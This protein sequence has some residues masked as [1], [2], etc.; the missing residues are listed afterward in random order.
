MQNV[1][2]FVASSAVLKAP[3]NR[4]PAT[5]PPTVRKPRLKYALGRRTTV[6]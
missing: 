1:S 3:Q 4:M 2:V 5:N 6:Q